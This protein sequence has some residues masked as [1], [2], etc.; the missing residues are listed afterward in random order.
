MKRYLL[1]LRII[2]LMLAAVFL[3]VG[4]AGSDTVTDIV[5]TE[6]TDTETD[7]DTTTVSSETEETTAEETSAEEGTSA[8]EET[9]EEETTVEDTTAADTNAEETTAEDEPENVSVSYSELSLDS[10]SE[11]KEYISD[12]ALD[13]YSLPIIYITTE[14][15]SE[16]TSTEEYISGSFS[17][18]YKGTETYSDIEEAS[19]NVRGRGHSSWKLDKKSY[20]IKFDKKTSLF[21]LTA[22]K[23]WCLIAN[24]SDCSLIR[25]TLAMEMATVLDNFIFVPTSH[26]VDVFLNG[27][28]IGVY[29]ICEQ[30]EMKDGRIPGDRNS[31]EVDTDYLLEL[32]GNEKA[33]SFGNN[34]FATELCVYVTIEEPDEAVLTYAQ[35]S[36]ISSYLKAVDDAIMSGGG[37][38]EYID[39]PSFV[40]YFILLEFSYNTDG[41]FRRSNFIYKKAGGLLYMASPWDYDY[42]FGNFSL[43]T[44]SYDDWISLGNTK[45]DNW[46]EYIK[47]NWMTYLLKDDAFCEQLK[48]RWNEVGEALYNKAMSTIEELEV[49][50]AASAAENFAVW[51]D[52]LGTQIQY[53][54]SKTGAL[55]TWEEHIEYL[56]SFIEKRYKWMDKTINAM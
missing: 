3:F 34:V 15:G 26:M 19:M 4:C 28:Y 6:A 40:D 5:T 37:Y 51:D 21:G 29:S 10:V 12:G 42:A 49:T 2:S 56:K 25:N 11:L 7:A 24:H 8:Q 36:Y 46:N 23:E 17:I 13:T 38:E 27:T 39:V 53:Q 32:G 55:T 9:T 1:Q 16:I 18:F 31:T 41:V 50:V 30:I 45:T 48:E 43:D 44:Y 14:G 20:K 54:S 47:D 35:Y 22:A 52:I 33:T